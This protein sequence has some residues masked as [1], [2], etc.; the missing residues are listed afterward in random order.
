MK[1]KVL[2]VANGSIV[3]DANSQAEAEEKPE[4]L[5]DEQTAEAIDSVDIL[6]VVKEG[7]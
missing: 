3:I 5:S 2:F 4:H 6:D 1:F 7:K